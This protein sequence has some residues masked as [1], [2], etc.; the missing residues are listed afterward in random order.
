MGVGG[1]RVGVW[2]GW[3]C[4]GG[5][6]VVGVSGWREWVGGGNGWVAGVGGW[7]A[8]GGLRLPVRDRRQQCVSSKW[9]RQPQS[10]G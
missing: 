2:W 5:G 9:H 10:T 1:C 3:V 8:E 4:G 7:E 6:C